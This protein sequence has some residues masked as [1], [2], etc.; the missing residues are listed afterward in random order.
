MLSTMCVHSAT[1]TYPENTNPNRSMRDCEFTM[2]TLLF[3]T[4]SQLNNPCFSCT[5]KC[6]LAKGISGGM[7][8]FDVGM[9]DSPKLLFY[10]PFLFVLTLQA[11]SLCVSAPHA[12]KIAFCGDRR[13][14]RSSCRVRRRITR[15]ANSPS[16]SRAKSRMRASVV[17]CVSIKTMRI[18][19][20]SRRCRNWK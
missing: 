12:A 6:P 7:F 13:R 1:P 4:N 16:F 18:T 17:K 5:A 2:K 20:P 3:L 19:A 10:E 8:E 11:M 14:I 15:A 9:V